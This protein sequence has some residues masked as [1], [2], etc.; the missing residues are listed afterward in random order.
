MLRDVG[1]SE[2]GG[3]GISNPGHLFLV[4]DIQLVEQVCTP[5]SVEF[6]D[7]SVADFCDRQVDEGRLLEQFARITMGVQRSANMMNSTL[8]GQQD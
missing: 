1:P 3:F 4:E 2:V 8:I 6:D 5:V 7:D